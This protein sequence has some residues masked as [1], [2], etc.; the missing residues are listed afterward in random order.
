MRKAS[1]DGTIVLDT[2]GVLRVGV[3]FFD[4]ALLVFRSIIEET[5]NHHLTLVYRQAPTMQSLKRLVTNRGFEML[6]TD[7]G[8]W[9]ISFA[10]TS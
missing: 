10:E 1:V 4:E 6:E 2:S 9:V 8:E 7:A 3:S 5:G